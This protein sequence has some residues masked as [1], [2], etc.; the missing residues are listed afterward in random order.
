MI[1]M[2]S[3]FFAEA[4]DLRGAG[5]AGDVKADKLNSGCRA[6]FVDY[7]PHGLDDDSILIGRYAQVFWLSTIESSFGSVWS[8][9]SAAR[10]ADCRNRSDFFQQMRHIHFAPHSNRRMRA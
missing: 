8:I 1:A 9:V 5:F 3:A 7:R 6:G 4:D 10:I 2:F